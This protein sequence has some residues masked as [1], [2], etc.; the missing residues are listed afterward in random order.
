MRTRPLGHVRFGLVADVVR[1]PE[2][3]SQV[4]GSSS[5]RFAGAPNHTPP[6]TIA[7]FVGVGRGQIM[8]ALCS[9]RRDEVRAPET[10][11][12][13]PANSE[14]GAAYFRSNASPGNRRMAS[15]RVGLGSG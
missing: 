7:S 8:D 12:Y 10:G 13:L 1:A 5:P 3:K 14:T 15:G 2:A 11:S 4:R 9:P 6:A